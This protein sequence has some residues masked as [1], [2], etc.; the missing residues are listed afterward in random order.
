MGG[1]RLSNLPDA[2]GTLQCNRT[3]GEAHPRTDYPK[4]GM[5]FQSNRPVYPVDDVPPSEAEGKCT[6]NHTV[7]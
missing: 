7:G 1:R 3:R 5:W 2:P 6:A 4:D